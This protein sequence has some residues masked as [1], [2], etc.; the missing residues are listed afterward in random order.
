MTPNPVRDSWLLGDLPQPWQR[1]TF[2]TVA[3][4]VLIL[5]L[6][7]VQTFSLHF[8]IWS[9]SLLRGHLTLDTPSMRAPSSAYLPRGCSQGPWAVRALITLNHPHLL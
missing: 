2:P 9:P 3:L 6:L 4:H 7:K 5:G 1:D 8:P